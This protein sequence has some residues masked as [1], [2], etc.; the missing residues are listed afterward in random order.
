VGSR[1]ITLGVPTTGAASAFEC[2]APVALQHRCSLVAGFL[3][4]EESLRLECQMSQT[5]SATLL[6]STVAIFAS[7]GKLT[8]PDFAH[9]A[10]TARQALVPVVKM[11][12]MR[13]D[14]HGLHCLG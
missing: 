14:C 1:P 12:S 2:T 10:K 13:G 9:T 4:D 11:L 8:A 6:G 5:V 3:F 7:L